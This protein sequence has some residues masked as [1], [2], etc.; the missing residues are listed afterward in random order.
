MC[1]H[2]VTIYSS[3][4]EEILLDNPFKKNRVENLTT[5]YSAARAPLV[6]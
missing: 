2:L 1:Q 3:V 5:S 6:S 4:A